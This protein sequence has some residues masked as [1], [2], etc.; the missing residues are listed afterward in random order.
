MER[1]VPVLP[2][3]DLSVTKAF[4]VERLG[5]RVTWEATEDGKTGLMGIERGTMIITIDAPMS[6]HGRDACVS[7]HVD[8]ADAYYRE[9]REKVPISTPP[10]NEAWGA[11]TFGLS[12]PSGNTIFVIGPL[13]ESP[14]TTP[15]SA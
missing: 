10:R 3:D 8:D 7:L 1:A 6:G 2:A 12:D 15:K 9:W 14:I 13:P 11:R 4:Y 5:F